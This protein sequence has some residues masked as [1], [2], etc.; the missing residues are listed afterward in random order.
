MT[1]KTIKEEEKTLKTLLSHAVT[2]RFSVDFVL[3]KIA[4]LHEKSHHILLQKQ[5]E[6]FEGMKKEVEKGNYFQ[7]GWNYCLKNQ[8]THLKKLQE[9][10]NK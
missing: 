3:E 6:D 10:L 7:E 2:G 4:R 5:I 8:I 1:I 9:G